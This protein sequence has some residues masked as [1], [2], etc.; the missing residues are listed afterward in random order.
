VTG[1]LDQIDVPDTEPL[2]AAYV[3]PHAGYRY[4]G[5][6][7]AY[8]YARLRAHADEISRVVLVGPAHQVPLRGCAVPAATAWSTPLGEQPVDTDT[9]R[10]LVGDGHA[11]ADDAPHGPEHS[12]EVQIPFIQEALGKVP[13]VPIVAGQ[14]TPEDVLITLSAAIGPDTVLLCST[15]LS[16]YEPRGAAMTH[17]RRTVEAV[18]ARAPERIGVR[19]ACGIYALRGTLAWARLEGLLP[20]LLDLRTSADVPAG[21]PSRVVGYAA[22]AFR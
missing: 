8:V 16:H 22:F 21:D 15:D 17:D 11:K 2:A 13:V 18:L 1:L 6:T 12:P 14:C 3:V 9:C 4:S 19:D 7:A 5:L 20:D 10:A